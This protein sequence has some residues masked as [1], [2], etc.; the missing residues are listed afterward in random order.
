[1]RNEMRKF[2]W[3]PS[4][5]IMRL[6]RPA[7]LQGPSSTLRPSGPVLP[8]SRSFY[9]RAF[10]AFSLLRLPPPLPL[11]LPP[12]MSCPFRH[13]GGSVPCLPV[14][15]GCC[16]FLLSCPSAYVLFPCFFWQS[17]P[18][19]QIRPDPVCVSVLLQST[20]ELCS[21][22]L[23][24][25][26]IPSSPAAA[27]FSVCS[28][29]DPLRCHGFPQFSP[30]RLEIDRTAA[31]PSGQPTQCPGVRSLCCCCSSMSLAISWHYKSR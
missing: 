20:R 25:C 16:P 29:T 8:R 31:P 15:C 2:F 18:V 14:V 6:P 26:P 28:R 9:G 7:S 30:C 1:M 11:T 13:R 5:K 4:A 22:V 12:V 3:S 10:P 24:G 17:S 27:L 23:A 19:S 21:P